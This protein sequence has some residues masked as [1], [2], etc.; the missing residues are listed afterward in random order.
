MKL[1]TSPDA[2]EVAD[3]RYGV[4]RLVTRL[5][6]RRL[7]PVTIAVV[8]LTRYREKD[9]VKI[10]E[11]NCELAINPFPPAIEKWRKKPNASTND[12]SA[13]RSD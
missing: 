5:P 6:C 13:S 11:V 10:H 2:L 8:F 3:D 4:I 7:L 12:K 9:C 1:E